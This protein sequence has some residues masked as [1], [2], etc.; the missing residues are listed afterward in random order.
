MVFAVE[1][2]LAKTPRQI[3]DEGKMVEEGTHEKLL[4]AGGL[5]ATMYEQQKAKN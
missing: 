1:E 5:Y 3:M 2:R 4:L